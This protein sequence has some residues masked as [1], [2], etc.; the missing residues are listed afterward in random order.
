MYRGNQQSQTTGAI[1]FA[2]AQVLALTEVGRCSVPAED[3][4]CSS[5]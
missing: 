1:S 4:S 5:V 2:K 3:S